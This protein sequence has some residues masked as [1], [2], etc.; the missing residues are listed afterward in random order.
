MFAFFAHSKYIPCPECG[1][2]LAGEDPDEHVCDDARRLDFQMFRMRGHIARFD[3]DLAEF[4][5]TPAGKFERWYAEQ[6][7]LAA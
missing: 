3:D 2:S 4:L 7:R 1:A 5:E 6:Q